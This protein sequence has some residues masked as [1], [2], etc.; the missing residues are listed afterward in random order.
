MAG[1]IEDSNLDKCVGMCV[2]AWVCVCFQ[3][4]ERKF[5][6]PRKNKSIVGWLKEADSART[7]FDNSMKLTADLHVSL[8]SLFYL[9]C[10]QVHGAGDQPLRN[11]DGKTF[12][13]VLI[14][15]L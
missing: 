5:S 14:F 4:G 12:N 2:S 3:V 11:S 6:T 9:C 15:V 10:A 13:D 7:D 1:R 8:V